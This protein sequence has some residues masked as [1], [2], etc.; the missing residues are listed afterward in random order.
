ML[1][2]PLH[3]MCMSPSL[4]GWAKSLLPA[5]PALCAWSAHDHYFSSA[6]RG[7]E[8]SAKGLTKEASPPSSFI[9]DFPFFTMGSIEV[10]VTELCSQ[11]DPTANSCCMKDLIWNGW[12]Q[13]EI[14]LS[15]EDGFGMDIS[16]TEA[17]KSKCLQAV[18]DY[19]AAKKTVCYQ[20]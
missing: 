15:G 1:A 3:L 5:L 17:E 11:T 13:V 9:A 2:Q 8:S 16:D 7:P 19:T 14:T 10:S 12:D 20:K 6:S 4:P 18:A